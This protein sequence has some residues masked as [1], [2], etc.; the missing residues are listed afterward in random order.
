M[1]KKSLL[2]IAWGLI[3][4]LCLAVILLQVVIPLGINLGREQEARNFSV[5]VFIIGGLAFFGN[6]GFWTFKLSKE[7]AP[8][9]KIRPNA[10]NGPRRDGS[11]LI[12]GGLLIAGLVQIAVGVFALL[13]MYGIAVLIF[14]HAFGVELPNP[15]H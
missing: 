15:F 6:V 8:K 10:I 1:I 7:P 4:V 3:A 13:L 5:I 12:V 14:R 2:A 9:P 11:S